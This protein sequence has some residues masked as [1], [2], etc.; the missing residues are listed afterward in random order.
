MKATK[1]AQHDLSSLALPQHNQKPRMV[2]KIRYV[3]RMNSQQE[4]LTYVK[5]HYLSTKIYFP[6]MVSSR[7]RS[8]IRKNHK[9]L[10]GVNLYCLPKFKLDLEAVKYLSLLNELN[11]YPTK[12]KEKRRSMFTYDINQDWELS[13]FQYMMKLSFRGRAL[14]KRLKV[15][16]DVYTYLERNRRNQIRTLENL[17]ITTTKEYI[18]NRNPFIPH[19][20]TNKDEKLFNMIPH[21][22]DLRWLNN[23]RLEFAQDPQSQDFLMQV[24]EK[25]SNMENLTSLRIQIAIDALNKRLVKMKKT[26]EKFDKLESLLLHIDFLENKDSGSLFSSLLPLKNLERLAVSVNAYPTFNCSDLANFVFAIKGLQTLKIFTHHFIFDQYDILLKKVQK[27]K[28]LTRLSIKEDPGTLFSTFAFGLINKTMQALKLL[29]HLHI[30]IGTRAQDPNELNS[31]LKC[32]IDQPLLK[33]VNVTLSCGTYTNVTYEF[34]DHFEDQIRTLVNKL[35]RLK[36]KIIGFPPDVIR[37]VGDI[38]QKFRGGSP[39]HKYQIT[40]NDYLKPCF[41]NNLCVLT[42]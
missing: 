2:P 18:H 32:I 25:L 20:M 29:E 15:G 5:R 42:S 17:Y 13:R 28:N 33:K 7:P 37:K 21:F 16:M 30:E 23:L 39:N 24:F 22:F 31:L 36:L 6:C 19:V 10:R 38:L 8:V 35:P 27:L 41:R 1:L 3:S 34:D 4:Y 40:L 12:M 11:V 9:H 14:F 26:M